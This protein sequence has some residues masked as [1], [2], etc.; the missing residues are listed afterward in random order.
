MSKQNNPFNFENPFE[1]YQSFFKSF[2]SKTFGLDTINEFAQKNLETASEINKQIFDSAVEVMNTQTAYLKSL[3]KQ[4]EDNS[5]AFLQNSDNPQDNVERSAE[6]MKSSVEDSFNSAQ[7]TAKV[8]GDTNKKV[9]EI[10]SKRVSE[11]VEEAKEAGKTAASKA[12]GK[13][14][15]A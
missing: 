2:D 6:F 3:G 14:K 4:M 13:S 10:V 12:T 8:I 5:K 9:G 1:S 7:K 11:A 15:A